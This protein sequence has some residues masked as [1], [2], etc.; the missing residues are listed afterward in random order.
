ML[1]IIADRLRFAIFT[2][3]TYQPEEHKSVFRTMDYMA[4][5]VLAKEMSV[6]YDANMSKAV[7]RQQ[8]KEL[9]AKCGANTVLLW[10]QTPFEVAWER[11]NERNTRQEPYVPFV[12]LDVL[13]RLQGEF[14][15]PL[16]EPHIAIDGMASYEAQLDQLD[17]A[18]RNYSS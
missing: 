7:H 16:N 18:L 1:H 10:F 5:E 4:G 6:M 2:T 3:P 13:R 17:S 14:E 15:A 9:A 8:K 12:G 11:I